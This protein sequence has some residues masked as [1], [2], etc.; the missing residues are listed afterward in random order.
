[1]RRILIAVGLLFI[2]APAAH[3]QTLVVSQN[4]CKF[5]KMGEIRAF[6]DTA[7]IPIAQEL[8]NEGKLLAA[9]S[10]FHAWGDEWNVLYW[11]TAESVSAFLEGWGELFARS[12]ERNPDAMQ[13]FSD[14]C[15]EHKDSMY[16]S[17][18]MTGPAPEEGM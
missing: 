10:A 17:G 3:S 7:W 8:V 9:G 11:Y 6:A 16:S 15:W 1:M 2:V 12:N 5:E 14:W 4:K 13:M 18:E